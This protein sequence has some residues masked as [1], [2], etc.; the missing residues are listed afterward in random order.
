LNDLSE[1]T[2]EQIKGKILERGAL[3]LFK[4][5]F[6][7]GY[8]EKI[9]EILRLI[10]SVIDKETGLEAIESLL[11]YIFSTTEKSE[12]ELREIAS[13]C[14]P[15]TKENI[16]MKLAE[17]LMLKGKLEGIQEGTFKGKLEGI[18]EGIFDIL[19]LRFSEIPEALKH[20]LTRI[21]DFEKLRAIHKKAL[22]IDSFDEL[23]TVLDS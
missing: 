2:D 18:V 5:V 20:R 7:P 19:K 8:E 3:L 13:K 1:Y 15:E 17:R 16:I 6:Q 14:L 4:Y 23:Q 12:E 11:R 10:F 21:K 9:P 22:V